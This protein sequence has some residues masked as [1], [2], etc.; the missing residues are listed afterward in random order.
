MIR[1]TNLA[2]Y[3]V[4]LMTEISSGYATNQLYSAG[5]LSDSTTIPVTTVAKILNLLGKADLLVSTRGLKGGFTLSRDP[6]DI[7]M[8]QIIEAIDGPIALT[9]CVSENR[10]DCNYEDLCHMRPHWTLINIKIKEA[11]SDV[12]LASLNSPAVDKA[13]MTLVK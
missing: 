7:S 10:K 2:D 8:A 13:A 12:S 5:G 4:L 6:K 1:L 3:A 11:L 9:N